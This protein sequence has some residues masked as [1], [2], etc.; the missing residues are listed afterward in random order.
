MLLKE[1]FGPLNEQQREALEVIQ[2]SC[3]GISQVLAELSELSRLE[4][5]KAR[6][7]RRAV[8]LASVLS[9]TIAAL[10]ELPERGV[11]VSL[12]ADD[13]LPVH[14]DAARLR[15]AF[16]AILHALRR[17]LVTSDELVVRAEGRDEDDA[18]TVRIVIGAPARIEQLRQSD[19]SAL[20]PFDEWQRGGNGLSLPNARR[21][22]EAHGGRL[23]SLPD[24]G[25]PD[26][27]ANA[28]VELPTIS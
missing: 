17:E 1:S 26:G 6:F 20:A 28:I 22:I 7:N 8:N 5:G 13:T 2:K 24:T 12:V 3:G 11:R 19:Q 9:D 10:P 21:I 23:S 4:A 15:T 27:K 18:A 25:P 16:S 14:G